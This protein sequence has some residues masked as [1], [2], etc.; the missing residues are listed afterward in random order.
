MNTENVR[1][2]TYLRHA[3][4]IDPAVRFFVGDGIS[5]SEPIAPEAIEH[6]ETTLVSYELSNTAPEFRARGLQFPS[7]VVDVVDA[8]RL[9]EGEPVTGGGAA[10]NLS[11]WYLLRRYTDVGDRL[12]EMRKLALGQG[13]TDAEAARTMTCL[14]AALRDLW[15]RTLL[16]LNNRGESYRFASV[17]APLTKLLLDAEI[18]GIRF[19]RAVVEDRLGMLSTRIARAAANLRLKWNILDLSDASEISRALM[20]DGHVEISALLREPLSLR[21]LRGHRDSELDLLPEHNAVVAE[22]KAF[23]AATHDKAILLHLSGQPEGVVYPRYTSMGTVTGRV[24][25][26]YPSL[27]YMSRKSRDILVPRE[28]RQFLYADFAQFEPGILADESGD[29]VLQEDYNSG[30]L[31]AKFSTHVFGSAVHRERAKIVLL[32]FCYGMTASRLAALLTVDSGCVEDMEA[33]IREFIDRYRLLEDWRVRL[34]E[35][36]S[37]NRRIG[38]RL[39]NFR[40]SSKRSAQTTGADQRAALSQRV[41]GT[42]S[43]IL[44]RAMLGVAAA[45][46]A[47]VVLPMHDAVLY[48]VDEV[49][50]TECRETIARV[51]CETF[52]A[53]CPSVKSRV[54]FKPFSESEVRL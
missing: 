7:N 2:L 18:R 15:N 46:C 40:Y 22:L 10:A 54:V 6:H 45:D 33:L 36:L 9:A 13:A 3:I 32:A 23:R 4:A 31:Y 48:E 42:A 20:S 8:V 24:I 26:R 5:P 21:T 52:S 35:E 39:G 12:S 53:E 16:E 25:V 49:C 14:A 1:F 37:M 38:T 19:N 29:P 51:F 50:A 11:V 17:E 43:L 28:G 30:D 34:S 44:K 27:Q 47:D 41:Q